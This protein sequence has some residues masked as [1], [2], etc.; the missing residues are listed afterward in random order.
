MKKHKKQ[1][2]DMIALI[3]SAT[4]D[5]WLIRD[6]ATHPLRPVLDDAKPTRKLISLLERLRTAQTA[7]L[8]QIA[9]L[10][11]QIG[12]LK[13]Q[14]EDARVQKLAEDNRA[15]Q[16]KID[17]IREIDRTCT[18]ETQQ[19]NERL[20]HEVYQLQG[21]LK[22]RT[23]DQ[24]ATIYELR[25]ELKEKSKT[26]AMLYDKI[27]RARATLA[28]AA[29]GRTPRD[30]EER[31]KKTLKILNGDDGYSVT[32]KVSGDIPPAPEGP[33]PRDIKGPGAE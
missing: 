29:F 33:G 26:V 4:T 30:M 6:M 5:T 13:T 9:R 24:R 22:S 28:W 11:A 10:T 17:R 8:E 1:V 7:N 27:D 12:T 3:D 15:L 18:T 25:E 2:K 20:R 32:P 23:K 19:E 21:T 14:S 16:K 31:Q